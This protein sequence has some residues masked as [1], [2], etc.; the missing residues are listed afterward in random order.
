[1]DGRRI[2][3]PFSESDNLQDT[4]AGIERDGEDITDLDPVAGRFLSRAVDP[5]VTLRD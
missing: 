2:T 5:D 1:M 4:D 3:T